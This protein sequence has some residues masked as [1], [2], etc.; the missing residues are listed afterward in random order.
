MLNLWLFKKI[1]IVIWFG[2]INSTDDLKISIDRDSEFLAQ[3]K[4]IDYSLLLI[5]DKATKE[6]K[7]GIIDYMQ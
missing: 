1:I 5:I 4:V 2:F 3:S 7:I 6:L